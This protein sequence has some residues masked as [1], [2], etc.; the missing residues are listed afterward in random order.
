MAREAGITKRVYPHLL[1][2]TMTTLPFS[3]PIFSIA[4][5]GRRRRSHLLMHKRE[6]LV[7]PQTLVD[8][9]PFERSSQEV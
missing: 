4:V 3:P 7:L 1:R 9:P 8:F 6:M 5:V 2:H